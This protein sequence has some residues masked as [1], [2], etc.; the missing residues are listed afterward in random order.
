[1]RTWSTDGDKCGENILAYPTATD[2]V[3]RSVLVEVKY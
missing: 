3:E 1:M 2:G